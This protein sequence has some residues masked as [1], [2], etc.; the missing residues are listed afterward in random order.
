MLRPSRGIDQASRYPDNILIGSSCDPEVGVK[1]PERMN[2]VELV[3]LSVRTV[4]RCPSGLGLTR[5]KANTEVSHGTLRG[6]QVS[7]YR[8]ERDYV[9]V[10][11]VSDRH[12]GS[13]GTVAF[14]Y[15]SRGT[16]GQ[17]GA[18]RPLRA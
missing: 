14:E 8:A 15:D 13:S 6:V 17:G 12:H 3:F 18:L 16:P 5:P 9:D 7:R 4:Y 10:R 11:V 2:I 1:T